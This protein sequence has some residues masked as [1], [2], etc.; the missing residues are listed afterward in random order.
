MPAG[1]GSVGKGGAP[2]VSPCG[3]VDER[4]RPGRP[5]AA[6]AGNPVSGA[7]PHGGLAGLSAAQAYMW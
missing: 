7:L 2:L 3:Q 6:V 5:G 1:M 4:R